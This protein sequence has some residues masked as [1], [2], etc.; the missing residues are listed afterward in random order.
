MELDP[1]VKERLRSDKGASLIMSADE[2]AA[3]VKD[4]MVLGVSGF[5]ASGYPKAVPHA[6]AESTARPSPRT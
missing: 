2:A 6:L 3:M 1:K 5:T 4:G